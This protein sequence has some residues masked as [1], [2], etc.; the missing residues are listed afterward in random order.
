MLTYNRVKE[1]KLTKIWKLRECRGALH[2][3]LIFH[4]CIACLRT[5]Q[6]ILALCLSVNESSYSDMFESI[7]NG[8]L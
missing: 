5:V 3:E 1:Q 8:G 2:I 6:C 7:N 4:V